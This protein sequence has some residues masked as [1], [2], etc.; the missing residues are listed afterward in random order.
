MSDGEEYLRMATCVGIINEIITATVSGRL[1]WSKKTRACYGDTQVEY[2]GTISSRVGAL[3]SVR[4]PRCQ[5]FVRCDYDEVPA[6]LDS[7]GYVFVSTEEEKAHKAA[8]QAKMK[9]PRILLPDE[10][11]CTECRTIHNTSVEVQAKLAA[12]KWLRIDCACGNKIM[13]P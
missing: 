3:V 7:D 11:F 6:F 9:P 10:F 13:L 2:R 8:E 12:G 5:G 4:C 1:K